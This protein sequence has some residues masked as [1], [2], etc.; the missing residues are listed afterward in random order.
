MAVNRLGEERPGIENA[1]S[2]TEEVR[3]RTPCG[4]ETRA[5]LLGV[6]SV[7]KKPHYNDPGADSG[8]ARTWSHETR[9]PAT[10]PIRDACSR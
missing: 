7:L 9:K 6:R 10:N 5:Q 8:G 3:R 4:R 1:E 2:K